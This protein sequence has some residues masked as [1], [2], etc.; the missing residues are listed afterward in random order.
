MGELIIDEGALGPDPDFDPEDGTD[1]CDNCGAPDA[2]EVR[3]HEGEPNE[4]RAFYCIACAA[5]AG[6]RLI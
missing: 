5:L 4:T 6:R 1:Y 2:D 3:F